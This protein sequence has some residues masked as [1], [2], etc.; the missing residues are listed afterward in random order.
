MEEMK[1]LDLEY[2]ICEVTLLW[3]RDKNDMKPIKN[4]ES[5]HKKMNHYSGRNIIELARK[6][7]YHKLSIN[8]ITEMRF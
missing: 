1:Y 6:E 8:F 2:E 3:K 7:G 4:E 5:N